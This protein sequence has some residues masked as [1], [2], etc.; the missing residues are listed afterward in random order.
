MKRSFPVISSLPASCLFFLLITLSIPASAQDYWDKIPALTSQCYD[1]KDDFVKK[2][3]D[4][5]TEVKTKMEKSRQATEQKLSNMSQEEKMAFAMRYQNMAPEEIMQRQKD[6][7]EMTQ[8]QADF[9]QKASE[10]ETRYTEIE[11][12]FRSTFQQR[13]GPIEQ[14][15]RKLPDGEGT[16]QWAIE[17]AEELMAKYNQEYE[18]ICSEYFTS[19]HAKFRIWLK[20]FNTFLL[21]DEI[22]FN[23][24]RIQMEY[25]QFGLTPDGSVVNLMA[26]D[27]Y[28]EK[29]SAIFKLRRPYPQG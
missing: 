12:D 22:P 25:G 11:S 19:T 15:A 27:R 3:Q 23:D 5:R 8:A 14:E 13:L 28:L 4:L 16:P 29:C 26:V 6:M 10:F 18:M 21:E 7:M 2:V 20:D 9:Q 17:K 24:K 1:D